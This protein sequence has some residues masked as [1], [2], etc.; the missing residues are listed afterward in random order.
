MTGEAAR[1]SACRLGQLRLSITICGSLEELLENSRALI[2]SAAISAG[3]GADREAGGVCR[4]VRSCASIYVVRVPGRGSEH[5]TSYRIA[6]S[7]A[8]T[9][10]LRPG[11]RLG[12]V[13]TQVQTYSVHTRHPVPDS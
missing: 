1:R 10:A 13:S 7:Y 8:S 2:R 5:R 6:L 4:F 9:A 11:S 3:E 12:T